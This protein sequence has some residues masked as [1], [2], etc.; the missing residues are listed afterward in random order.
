MCIFGE[1]IDRRI[2][3]LNKTQRKPGKIKDVLIWSPVY[4]AT[5][6]SLKIELPFCSSI[7]R[8]LLKKI[9][10]LETLVILGYVSHHE[11]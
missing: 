7:V 2:K 10:F 5:E 4:M 6:K 9:R 3:K 8:L 1:G 11:N